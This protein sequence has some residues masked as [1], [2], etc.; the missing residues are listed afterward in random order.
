MF[1]ISITDNTKTKLTKFCLDS[2]EKRIS[3]KCNVFAD[4][5]QNIKVKISKSDKNTFSVK[6]VVIMNNKNDI[7]TALSNNEDLFE[8]IDDARNKVYTQVDKVKGKYKSS[9]RVKE[10]TIDIPMPIEREEK[11]EVNVVKIKTRDV[12]P[13]LMTEA[14][15]QMKLLNHDFFI[16]LDADT[17]FVNVLYKRKTGDYGLIET[18]ISNN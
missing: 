9:K 1:D 2:V 8:A 12:K 5:I 7:I 6:I 13:M 11:E 17:N 10:K 15:E 18:V 4:Y 3:S 16:Y 14:L